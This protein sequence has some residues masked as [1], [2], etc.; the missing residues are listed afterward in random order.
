MSQ[1]P[2]PTGDALEVLLATPGHR[3]SLRHLAELPAREGKRAPWPAWA[4]PA[5]VEAYR[6]RGVS[7]PWV[8]QVE[9]A[10][11]V[12]AGR[13]TVLATGTGSGKSLAAWLPALSAI[14]AGTERG[15]SLARMRR[16]P[17]VLYLS[18]TKALAADQLSALHELLGAGGLRSD[19]RAATCDGD[20]APE[21]RDWVRAHAD[22][23]LTNPDF[24]HFSLLPGHERW[25][26]MLRGLRY[27][28]IDECHAYRGVLGAHV[29]LVLRRLLRVARHMGADPVVIAA[30][31]T[32]GNRR[33]R[34][35]ASSRSRSARSR[36]SPGTPRPRVDGASHCG[37]RLPWRGSET[38]THRRPRGTTALTTPGPR[39]QGCPTTCLAAAPPRS[40]QSCSPTS[41]PRGDAPWPSSAPGWGW[42]RWPR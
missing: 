3:E 37:N 30:S 29:A 14:L 20:T 31:A 36:P 25:D 39:S 11:H 16:R 1:D 8:H 27:I 19:L 2:A 33:P 23:V 40:P 38:W 17:T 12:H 13:H 32:T 41:S 15:G 9:A 28:V 5:L 24:L 21:E 6:A 34:W 26:R 4:A 10:D 35:R 7:E 22:V 42:R 18:P